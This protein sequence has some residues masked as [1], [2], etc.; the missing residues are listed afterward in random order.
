MKNR[1]QFCNLGRKAWARIKHNNKKGW[2]DWMKVGE[3]LALGRQE[4]KEHLGITTN[5]RKLGGAFNT[6]FAKWKKLEGLGDVD[7]RYAQHLMDII[8]NRASIEDYRAGLDLTT[9][10][11]LN[12][13]T[14][15][16]RHWK[17]HTA[18]PKDKK[19]STAREDLIKEN[20]ALHLEVRE[21]KSRVK[22]LEEELEFA[23]APAPAEVE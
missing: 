9:R 13:P 19:K 4:V 16:V 2:E 5:K 10:L 11:G 8:D 7:G 12:N 23:R 15:M 1:E 18:I 22:E 17:S 21:L 6:E 3:M 20:E 14:S